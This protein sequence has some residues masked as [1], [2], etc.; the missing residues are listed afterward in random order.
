M[1]LEL[2]A[3]FNAWVD[4]VLIEVWSTPVVAFN[5]NLYE[6]EEEFA[7]QLVGTASFDLSD[8]DW[9]CDE[10]F[11]SG[12]DLFYLPHAVVGGQWQ[13]GLEAANT[14]V[15]NYL[16][17][18]THAALLKATRGVGVGFVDGNIDIVYQRL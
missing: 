14:L 15:K 17:R 9:G 1:A 10:V 2:S 16:Q 13:N 8:E 11:S 4:R 6:H 12:E 3:Q 18:G 7:I 5:F